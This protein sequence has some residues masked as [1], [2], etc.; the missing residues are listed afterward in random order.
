MLS[1]FV[2]IEGIKNKLQFIMAIMSSI[3]FWGGVSSKKSCR[4]S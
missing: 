1:T 2:S 3:F 4:S